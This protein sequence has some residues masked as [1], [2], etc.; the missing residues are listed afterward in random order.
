MASRHRELL[1]NRCDHS[2]FRFKE[3]PFRRRRRNQHA[4]RV[5]SPEK[6]LLPRASETS[7]KEIYGGQSK[8]TDPECSLRVVCGHD[9][10]DVSKLSGGSTQYSAN[11]RKRNGRVYLKS[12]RR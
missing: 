9:L 5:R 6:T 3:S 2:R 7:K 10:N 8:Q 11:V 1:L 12:F 4:R